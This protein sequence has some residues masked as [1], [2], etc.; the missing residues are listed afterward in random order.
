MTAPETGAVR[1]AFAL[2]VGAALGLLY[3]FLRP[4]R[5]KHGFLADG[6]FFA[7]AVSGLALV[8]LRRLRRGSPTGGFWGH[9][10][11]GNRVGNHFGEAAASGFSAFLGHNWEIVGFSSAAR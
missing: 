8:G 4:L 6:V 3:G 7:G 9:G 1:F 11:G 5:P 2:A 10:T